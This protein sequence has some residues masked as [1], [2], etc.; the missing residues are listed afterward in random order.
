M[1]KS[2]QQKHLTHTMIGNATSGT[3]EE[4]DAAF[5]SQAVIN[6]PRDYSITNRQN[7]EQT[8]RKGVPYTYAVQVTATGSFLSPKIDGQGA[9][10][11]ID[12]SGN[13]NDYVQAGDGGTTLV[14]LGDKQTSRDATMI[15]RFFAPMSN[16]VKCF[17]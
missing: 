13:I 3:G 6:Y 1:P 15:V 11:D 4:A 17:C 8:T 10:E 12:E 7:I 9:V 14:S 5:Y 16:W 2:I